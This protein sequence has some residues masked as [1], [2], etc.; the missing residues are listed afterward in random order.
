[1]IYDRKLLV[2]VLIAHQRKDAQ[3][4]ICGWGR[5]GFSH[6]EHIADMY[7]RLIKNA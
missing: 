5:L 4:C 3:F 2:E 6:A 7:E 1:M